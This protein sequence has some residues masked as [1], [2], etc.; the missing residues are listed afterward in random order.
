MSEYAVRRLTDRLEMP[1]GGDLLRFI[2]FLCAFFGALFCGGALRLLRTPDPFCK[3]LVPALI[4]FF[5]P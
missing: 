5:N 3:C 2:V 4:P 1:N